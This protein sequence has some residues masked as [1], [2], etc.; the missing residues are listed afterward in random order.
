MLIGH[1]WSKHLTYFAFSSFGQPL[2]K[3]LLILQIRKQT[4]RIICPANK[5]Q[6]SIYYVA[7]R[8]VIFKDF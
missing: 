5:G 4:Q 3:I 8:M 7:S 2:M 6:N 1:N